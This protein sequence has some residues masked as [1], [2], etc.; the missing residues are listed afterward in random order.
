MTDTL[1]KRPLPGNRVCHQKINSGSEQCAAGHPHHPTAAKNRLRA[2]E[3]LLASA[4]EL[5]LSPESCTATMLV[6]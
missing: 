6:I 3:E 5:T 2:V 1:C 4:E